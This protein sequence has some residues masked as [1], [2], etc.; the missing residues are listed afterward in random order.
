M[1]THTGTFC[2]A[3]KSKDWNTTLNQRYMNAASRV[4]L[5]CGAV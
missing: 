3:K 2:L 4:P 1:T 5:S